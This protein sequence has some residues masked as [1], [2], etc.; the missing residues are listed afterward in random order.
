MPPVTMAASGDPLSLGL[1]LIYA[2]A[3][4]VSPFGRCW[5]CRGFGFK[6]KQSRFTGRLSRGRDCRWCDATGRRLRL[7]RRLFN[8]LA[9]IGRDIR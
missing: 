5:H 3:C 4:F 2:A 9:D 7:G 6:L 1:L 8:F